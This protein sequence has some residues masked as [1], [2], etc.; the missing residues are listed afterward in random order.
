MNIFNLPL[1]VYVMM[2]ETLGIDDLTKLDTA[3]TNHAHREMVLESFKQ[4]TFVIANQSHVFR[5]QYWMSLRQL[6]PRY[7]TSHRVSA[8]VLVHKVEKLVVHD[9]EIKYAPR[10]PIFDQIQ[11]MDNLK[12]L[13]YYS[14]HESEH[15]LEMIGSIM[16]PNKLECIKMKTPFLNLQIMD[17]FIE[18]CTSC[19]QIS[20]GTFPNKEDVYDS[21]VLLDGLRFILQTPTFLTYNFSINYFYMI[22]KRENQSLKLWFKNIHAINAFHKCTLPPA[23]LL[24]KLYLVCE[25]NTKYEGDTNLVRW[26]MQKLITQWDQSGRIFSDCTIVSQKEHLSITANC[27]TL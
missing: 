7:W 20:I 12:Y 13:E 14:K 1:S 26:S 15:L 6:R 19:R 3:C 27:I 22:Y 11:Y 9:D 21:K 2:L 25:C 8:K 5:S 16:Q 24:E 18:K 10:L 23:F 17:W 4:N